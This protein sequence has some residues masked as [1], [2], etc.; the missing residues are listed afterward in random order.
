MFRTILASVAAL[1]LGG[2]PAAAC[3]VA[4]LTQVD[5][6]YPSGRAIPENILR[7]YLYFTAPMGEADILP[8]ISLVRADGLVIDDAFLE[9][10]FDLWSPDRTRLTLLFDPARVKT[11]LEAHE[12]LGRA[13]IA[14]ESYELRVDTG[15]ADAQ[16]CPLAAPFSHSYVAVA[17]DVEPP[18]PRDWAFDTPQ[19]DTI[20]PLRIVL[21]SSHD[22]ASM[23]F[24]IQVWRDGERLPGRVELGTD[25][26]AWIFTPR[27]AW[28]T[29]RHEIR[30]EEEL[31]DL[32]GNRPGQLFDQP[33][34]VELPMPQ[35]SLSFLPGQS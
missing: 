19:A 33:V 20:E 25:E 14:G 35:L 34:G 17:S 26:T 12:A 21:G 13:L 29:E 7:L 8:H 24:R 30:I 2:H 6:I 9:N 32:A 4:A 16:G 22:H 31:E 10:R 28:A 18:D 15:A 27:R 3:S 5:A 11:G 1:Y 23:A